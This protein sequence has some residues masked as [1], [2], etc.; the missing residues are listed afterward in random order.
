MAAVFILSHRIQE[1]ERPFERSW[2]REVPRKLVKELAK[3][4]LERSTAGAF[5]DSGRDSLTSSGVPMRVVKELVTTP[6]A[7]LR[8]RDRGLMPHLS[9]FERGASGA[10]EGA[11]KKS[12]SE[13]TQVRVDNQ[14][15][16]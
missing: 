15:L 13:S 16:C 2:L 4:P 8:R 5:G 12:P 3:V 11:G 7:D 6:P 9:D 10:H 1:R 14:G